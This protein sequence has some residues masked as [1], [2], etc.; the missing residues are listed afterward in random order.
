MDI[1]IERM[2][3]IHDIYDRH[4]KD[5]YRFCIYLSADPML[6][7]DL[8]AEAFVRAWAGPGIIVQETVKA[9]LFTI[10]RNLYLHE[11]RRR[12]RY[13]GI[14]K[15][16]PDP[17]PPLELRTEHKSELSEVFAALQHLPEIE[18]SALIMR[19]EQ[20]MSYSD[21]AKSLGISVAAAKVRVHRARKK[22]TLARRSSK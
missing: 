18:R 6:A 1:L 8:T 15:D 2:N 17:A 16:V 20:D 12:A 21:I 3:D 11:L 7:E 14:S 10:A 13:A 9:Y 22:L 19:S 5:V 4:A